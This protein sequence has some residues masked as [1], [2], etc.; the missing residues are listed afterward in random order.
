[1]DV[2]AGQIP[3]TDAAGK[4]HIATDEQL[5]LVRKEAKTAW[6]MAGHF[7]HLKFRS[8]KISSRRFF[9]KTVRLR[10]FYLQFEAEIPKKLSVRNHRRGRGMTAD[11][12]IEPI[13]DL[14]DVLDVIDV[15]MGEQQRF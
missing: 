3:S 2:S 10:R 5:V 1:M 11:L 9:D 4:K 8:E 15:A 12:T 13:F 7:E 6:T 14:G